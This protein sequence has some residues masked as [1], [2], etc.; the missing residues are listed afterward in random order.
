[1]ESEREKQHKYTKACEFK[2]Q[3]LTQ[4]RAVVI[5]AGAKS[6]FCQAGIKIVGYICDANGRHPDTFKVLKSWTGQSA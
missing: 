6:Q 2:K 3:D 5:I 1:M 4:V